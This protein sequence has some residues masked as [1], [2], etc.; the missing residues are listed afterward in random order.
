[1]K[2]ILIAAY[3]Q[4]RFLDLFELSQRLNRDKNISIFIYINRRVFSKYKNII[5]NSTLKII[6]D[7]DVINNYSNKSIKTSYKKNKV[8]T[9]VVILFKNIFSKYFFAQLI[10]ERI[11][12]RYLTNKYQYF[13]RIMV[14]NKIDVVFSTGDRHVHE[15]PAILKSARDLGISIMLPYLTVYAEYTHIMRVRGSSIKN[16]K[17]I[18]SYYMKNKFSD[19]LHMGMSYYPF[20]ILGAIYK[21]KAL[22]NNPWVMGSGLSDII[23]LDSKKTYDKYTSYGVEKRKLKIVGSLAYDILYEKYYKRDILLKTLQ[24]KYGLSDCKKNIIIALPQFSEHKLMSTNKHLIEVD[25]ILTS[26]TKT[27]HNILISLHPKMEIDKYKFLEKKFNCK[28]LDERL[29]NV[30]PAA[31]LFIATYSSTVIWSIICGIKTIV[32]DFYGF[33]SSI[34][35]N[36]DSIKFVNRKSLLVSSINK[37]IEGNIDFTSDWEKL[38]RDEVFDNGVIDRYIKIINKI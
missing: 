15:E 37:S 34:F 33:N 8:I 14:E 13:L 20:Y 2:N 22:S 4:Q 19:Y 35:N 32:M 5:L 27:H 10:K 36:L 28:I 17:G 1:M 25:F 26:A 7:P 23:F 31:D 12:Y 24:D 6:L 38:S 29:M 16:Q 9:S 3:D 11:Y 18:Y 21:F 30:L